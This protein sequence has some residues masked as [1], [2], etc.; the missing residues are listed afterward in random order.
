[1]SAQKG[2][3]FIAVHLKAAAPRLAVLTITVAHGELRTL[4]DQC[5]SESRTTQ[6]GERQT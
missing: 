3:V 5:K 4:A 6:T 1:M 2:H